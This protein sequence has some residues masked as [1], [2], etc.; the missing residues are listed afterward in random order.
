[1]TLEFHLKEIRLSKSFWDRKSTT[2]ISK[3]LQVA[4][5]HIRVPTYVKDLIPKIT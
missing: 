5:I 3:I 2:T 1:M 4:N